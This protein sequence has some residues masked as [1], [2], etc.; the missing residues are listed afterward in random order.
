M[1]LVLEGHDIRAIQTILHES[2]FLIAFWF[3]ELNFSLEMA[4]HKSLYCV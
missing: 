2:L 3:P 4:S 1:Q